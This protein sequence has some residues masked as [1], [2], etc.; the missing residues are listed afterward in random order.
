MAKGF[1]YIL[2]N[3]SF[4][5]NI[6]KVGK[7]TNIEKRVKELS[8][9][10]GVPTKFQVYAKMETEHYDLVETVL[11]NILEKVVHKR[12]N[13]KRE[14]FEIPPEEAYFLMKQL[15]R[16]I[17]DAEITLATD[18]EDNTFTPSANAHQKYEK[19]ENLTLEAYTHYKDN[20]DLYESLKSALIGLTDDVHVVYNKFY[21]AFK[22]KTNF[23]DVVFQKKGLLLSFNM[24]Y[25]DVIDPKHLTEDVTDKGRWGNGDVAMHI[26]SVE[27]LPDVIDFA[28]QALVKQK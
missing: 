10:T 20:K 1:V 19:A 6:I 4:K 11:H 21:I 18:Q 13:A 22:S 8:Q 7:S 3:P 15:A 12:V 2:I 17:D 27:A 26:S 28:K 5:D 25:S 14:F 9:A 16:L 24:K 23:V